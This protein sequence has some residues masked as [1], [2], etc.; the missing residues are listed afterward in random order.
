MI[1]PT[2]EHYECH[3]MDQQNVLVP[4]KRR[5]QNGQLLRQNGQLVPR[6]YKVCMD[7]AMARI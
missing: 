3:E 1:N 5:D 7:C 6:N 4:C 2:W